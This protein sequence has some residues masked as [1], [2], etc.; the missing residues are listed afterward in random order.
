MKITSRNTDVSLSFSTIII[1]TSLIPYDVFENDT[2]DLIIKI[3]ADVYLLNLLIE[4]F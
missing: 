1:I 4:H 2:N 3:E